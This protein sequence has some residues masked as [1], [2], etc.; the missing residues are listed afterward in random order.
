MIACLAWDHTFS[1]ALPFWNCGQR[2]SGKVSKFAGIICFLWMEEYFRNLGG[3][4]RSSNMLVSVTSFV[5]LIPEL[6]LPLP[7]SSFVCVFSI[8]TQYGYVR[9]PRCQLFHLMTPSKCWQKNTKN[10]T[11]TLKYVL[12]QCYLD[13]THSNTVGKLYEKKSK[14]ESSDES[15]HHLYTYLNIY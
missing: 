2:H 14:Y 5:F 3:G 7:L 11:S 12:L 9:G 10:S 8:F 1:K 4:H 6:P 15:I 13:Q